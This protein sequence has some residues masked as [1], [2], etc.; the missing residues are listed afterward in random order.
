MWRSK[1]EICRSEKCGQGGDPPE[2]WE[3]KFVLPFPQLLVVGMDFW[4]FLAWRCISPIFSGFCLCHHVLSLCLH[5][6]FIWTQATL[7]QGPTLLQCD[8]IA[9]AKTLL[10]NQSHS[11][12]VRTSNTSFLRGHTVQP[13]A[14]CWKV[15]HLWCGREWYVQHTVG[16]RG[17]E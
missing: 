6:V 3:G 2:T 5:I 16:K 17:K 15:F 10:P 9:S 13:I 14:V 7:D 8:L 12:G 1:S 11:E 4:P